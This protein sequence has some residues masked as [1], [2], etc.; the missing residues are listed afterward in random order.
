MIELNTWLLFTIGITG[1]LFRSE[2]PF[3]I[4]LVYSIVR[5]IGG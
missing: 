3:A 1:I 4:L 2:I 5:L